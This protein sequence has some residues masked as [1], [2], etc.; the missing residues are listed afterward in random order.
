[1]DHSGDERDRYFQH[2]RYNCRFDGERKE[3]REILFRAMFRETVSRY[4]LARGSFSF[5]ADV[6]L[7]SW[8][9]SFIP[10]P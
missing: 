8:S 6:I 10:Y 3:V 9:D 2:F 7:A 4:Y 1:M 5:I